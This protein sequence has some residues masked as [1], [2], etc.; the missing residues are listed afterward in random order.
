MGNAEIGKIE[1]KKGSY[2]EVA[3]GSVTL[4]TYTGLGN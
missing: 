1:L 4:Y 2:V 3:E